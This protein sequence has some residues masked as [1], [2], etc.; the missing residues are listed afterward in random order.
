MVHSGIKTVLSSVAV[1]SKD[2]HRSKLEK[3]GVIYF[4]S[5]NVLSAKITKKY[6]GH[7]YSGVTTRYQAVT[8]S[9]R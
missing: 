4:F 8:L 1:G 3:I 2:R 9:S 7:L 6:Y 5:F